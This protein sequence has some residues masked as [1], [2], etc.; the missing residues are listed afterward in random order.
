MGYFIH[1]IGGCWNFIDNIRTYLDFV[2]LVYIFWLLIGIIT[3]LFCVYVV[4][5][6]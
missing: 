3:E 1:E 4:V 2:I 5:A 6:R